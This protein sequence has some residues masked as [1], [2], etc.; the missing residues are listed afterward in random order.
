MIVD[1]SEES[2]DD[3][4]NAEF[5]SVLQSPKEEEEEKEQALAT[6]K[7]HLSEARISDDSIVRS[8]RSRNKREMVPAHD[9]ADK[10]NRR[11]RILPPIKEKNYCNTIFDLTRENNALILQGVSDFVDNEDAGL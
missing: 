9:E 2:E 4:L 11:L 8:N 10:T 1:P 3:D 7:M 5:V 6:S